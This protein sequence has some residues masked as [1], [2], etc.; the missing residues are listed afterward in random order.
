MFWTQELFAAVLTVFPCRNHAVP[1]TVLLSLSLP[2]GPA[3]ALQVLLPSYDCEHPGQ[4][5]QGADW[6]LFQGICWG[7]GNCAA[8]VMPENWGHKGGP[9]PLD[10]WLMI[11]SV[12]LSSPPQ[13]YALETVDGKHQDLKYISP[14]MVRTELLL[15]NHGIDP[16]LC[17][18]H[19]YWH[20]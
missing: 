15:E 1:L 3:G 10:L 16:P 7:A 12:C 17:L 9:V 8:S 6:R 18:C 4:R 19:Q 20:S 2:E 13:G 14:E 11:L 5:S